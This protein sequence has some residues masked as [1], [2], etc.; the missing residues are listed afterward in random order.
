MRRGPP[1]RGI[2]VAITVH[3]V[4]HGCTGALGSCLAG[5]AE[6]WPLNAVGLAEAERLADGL[7]HLPFAAIVASPSLRAQQ[8]AAAIATH[9]TVPVTTEAGFDEI[10]FGDW[11]GRA[12]ADLH[13]DPLWQV[14]NR[15]RGLAQIPGGETMA[16]AQ[17]R[18][19]AALGR[20]RDAWPDA[21]VVVVSHADVIKAVLGN[22]LGAPLELMHRMA[23]EPASR[24]VVRLHGHDAEVLGINLPPGA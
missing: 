3:L 17:A 13:S 22:V 23:I 21:A 7:A 11:T 24:S 5:R 12:F 20:L 6:G 14:W 10:D 8:T 4:R 19:L 16:Q 15:H 9:G 18:A 2:E 1:P